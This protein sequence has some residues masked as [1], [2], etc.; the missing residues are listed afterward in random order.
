MTDLP[1]SPVIDRKN[2]AGKLADAINIPV[3]L[4][5]AATFLLPLADL[6]C[7]P[8]RA[9]F[10]GADL[11]FGTA[12]SI[13]TPDETGQRNGDSGREKEKIAR[14]IQ[15]EFKETDPLLVLIPIC[16]L[17]GAFMAFRAF[18]GYNVNT[19]A[20]R[21]AAV[22]LAL[23]F[24]YYGSV[25]FSAEREF[26]N[27]ARKGDQAASITKTD[28]FKMGLAASWASLALTLGRGM[29]PRLRIEDAG[30][31]SK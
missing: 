11:A 7:G 18:Q 12:P 21:V 10:T 20:L 1:Q 23:L 27:N 5:I 22:C 17:A 25:G 9:R 31:E 3:F 24:T 8:I 19:Q 26:A 29:S 14:D 13:E 30:T 6:N 16:G 15:N 28:W 4:F 2:D